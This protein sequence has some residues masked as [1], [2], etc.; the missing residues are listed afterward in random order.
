MFITVIQGFQNVWLF[1]DGMVT[2]L[3]EYHELYNA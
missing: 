1:Y 3:L 2:A